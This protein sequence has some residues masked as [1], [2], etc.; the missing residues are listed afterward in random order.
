MGGNR[1]DRS[2]IRNVVEHLKQFGRLPRE[3]Y[4]EYGIILGL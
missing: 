3:R 2:S 4:E 1:Q